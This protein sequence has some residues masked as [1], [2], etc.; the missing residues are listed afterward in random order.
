MTAKEL[1]KSKWNQ[2]FIVNRI[3]ELYS[4]KYNKLVTADLHY[5]MMFIFITIS[6][7]T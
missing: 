2:L 6:P 1:L 5:L 7:L 4:Q 3:L